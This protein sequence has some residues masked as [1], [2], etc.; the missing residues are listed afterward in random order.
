MLAGLPAATA[1]LVSVAVVLT[2]HDQSHPPVVDG[3]WIQEP[4]STHDL[5]THS[6]A[7]AMA[8]SSEGKCHA[9]T[10]PTLAPGSLPSLEDLEIE[11]ANLEG[12]LPQ[13]VGGGNLQY[14][15]LRNLGLSGCAAHRLA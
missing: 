8:V 2:L 11:G 15:E 4:M 14:M 5:A 9:G 3:V 12:S 6:W 1:L 10:L 7:W 13:L